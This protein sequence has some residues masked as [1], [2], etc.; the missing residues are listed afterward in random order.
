M[1]KLGVLVDQASRVRWFEMLD[2]IKSLVGRDSYISVF[3]LLLLLFFVFLF[4]IYIYISFT[5]DLILNS[6]SSTRSRLPMGL[7]RFEYFDENKILIGYLNA[8]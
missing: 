6:Y 5:P 1:A 4:F 2:R 7:A 8:T 3:L